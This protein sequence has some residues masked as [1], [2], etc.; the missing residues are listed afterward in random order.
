MADLRRRV[1][2]HLQTLSLGFYDNQ[3]VG[4]LTSRL[5]NDVTV[6]QGGLT[7]NLLGHGAADWSR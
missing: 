6:V 5:S 7:G 4:E 3:R 2:A 1:F